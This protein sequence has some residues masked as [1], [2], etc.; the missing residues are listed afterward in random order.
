MLNIT[1]SAKTLRIFCSEYYLFEA[2][3]GSFPQFGNRQ[4][5]SRHGAQRT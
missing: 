5:G 2:G 3:R 4:G 1:W